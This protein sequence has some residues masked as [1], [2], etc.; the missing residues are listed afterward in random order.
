[1]SVICCSRAIGDGGR[2]AQ[3]SRPTVPGGA[4]FGLHPDQIGS[5]LVCLFLAPFERRD[6][7]LRVLDKARLYRGGDKGIG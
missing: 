3:S 2:R 5:A 6:N 4:A 7:R 1:M